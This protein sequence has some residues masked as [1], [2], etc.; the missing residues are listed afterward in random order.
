[1]EKEQSDVTGGETWILD[2]FTGEE[3]GGLEPD[4]KMTIVDRVDRF[5]AAEYE[6]GRAEV[7]LQHGANKHETGGE[8]EDIVS[9]IAVLKASAEYHASQVDAQELH[10]AVLA[11]DVDE[12]EAAALL[13]RQ[14]QTEKSDGVEMNNSYYADLESRME[15]HQD[16]STDFDQSAS[17][18][19][20]QER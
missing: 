5:M 8:Y 1:M 4:P 14:E 15:D 19:E 13:S 12:S 17:R 2:R 20:G 11:Q 18:D 10:A 7:A 16:Q 6:L 3:A 9:A